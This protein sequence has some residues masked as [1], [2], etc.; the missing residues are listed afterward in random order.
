MKDKIW[1]E[2]RLLLGLNAPGNFTP[3]IADIYWTGEVVTYPKFLVPFFLLGLLLCIVNFFR[4]RSL[5][6]LAP[7]ILFLISISISTILTVIGGPNM[8][9]DCL[10]LPAIYF[11]IT[12]F[13]YETVNYF[14]HTFKKH[15][16]NDPQKMKLILRLV[17]MGLIVVIFSYQV[18]NYYSFGS[19]RGDFY[20]LSNRAYP[21]VKDYLQKN[22]AAKILIYGDDYGNAWGKYAFIRF[23]G[24]K[25]FQK[26]I[27]SGQITLLK[28]GQAQEKNRLIGQHYYNAVFILYLY[29]PSLLFWNLP[30]LTN[31]PY[32]EPFGYFRI[33][34]FK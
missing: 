15:H 18:G 14:Y 31:E 24:G 29:N 25:P 4:K 34:H 23:L 32:E 8:S 21:V 11:F 33:Y 28:P 6:L 10:A 20:D 30:I 17:L 5:T 16:Q 7:L 19:N 13:L 12:Y 2:C 22:P 27:E 9:R 3:P 26:E 1:N